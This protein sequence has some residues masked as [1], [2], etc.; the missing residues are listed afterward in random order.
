[1]LVHK[2]PSENVSPATV[3]GAWSDNTVRVT[4][5]VGYI[6]LNP[7]TASTQYDF[8]L[9]GPDGEKAFNRKNITGEYICYDKILVKGIY[10]MAISNATANEAFTVKMLAK[11]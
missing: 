8:S 11:E 6:Y 7:T 9:T 2:E 10:T 3:A 1:M 5:E 4:G